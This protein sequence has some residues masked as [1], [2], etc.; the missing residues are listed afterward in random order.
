MQQPLAERRDGFE[1][2]FFGGYC[3]RD[4]GMKPVRTM[5]RHEVRPLRPV[6]GAPEIPDVEEIADDDFCAELAEVLRA[7]IFA[8]DHG[9]DGEPGPQELLGD[10][11]AGV[12]GPR[13]NEDGGFDIGHQK[14]P[15]N[16]W[17][18]IVCFTK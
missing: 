14:T 13:G 12:A 6:H 15:G 4:R 10:G 16:M 9:P 18:S 5:R 1:L 3:E 17:F 8:A 11:A 7:M 2:G